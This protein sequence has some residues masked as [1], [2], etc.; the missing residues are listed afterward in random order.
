MSQSTDGLL[1]QEAQ[2]AEGDGLRQQVG[3]LQHQ[4][5]IGRVGEEAYLQNDGG[6]GCVNRVLEFMVERIVLAHVLGNGLCVPGKRCGRLG[7]GSEPRDEGVIFLGDGAP[8][9]AGDLEAGKRLVGVSVGV[10]GDEGIRL[11]VY[12]NRSGK[13]VHLNPVGGEQRRHFP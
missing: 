13:Q 9:G 3:L 1:G 2:D 4:V 7:G 12:R 10:N 5:L 8:R 11:L 6:R